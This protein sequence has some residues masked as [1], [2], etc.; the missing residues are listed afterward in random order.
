MQ[1]ADEVEIARARLYRL[2]GQ[3]L[4]NPPT[5]TLLSIATRLGAEQ[6][7]VRDALADLA[8]AAAD[9]SVEAARIEY[10]RLFIGVARGD[11]VPYA[12]YYLTG[13]LH[14]RPLAR[15]R[16]DMRRLGYERAPGRSDPEDH[17]AS[18]CEIMA[19]LIDDA[20]PA[21]AEFF[22]RHIDP[23]AHTFFADLERAANA[24]LYRP[25]GTLGR[26]TVELD[27]QA[28]ALSEATQEHRGA[29]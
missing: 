19:S 6:G 9:A 21:Q 26:V 4:A 27:R 17:I 7:A 25:V 13:F 18:V 2:L 20:D 10:D 11:L 3:F 23:W 15:L 1:P 5:S 22:A 8:E 28:F 29:A 14:E 24:R 12:S 16:A